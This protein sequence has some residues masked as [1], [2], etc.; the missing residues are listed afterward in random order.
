[1]DLI[2]DIKI[3]EVS[4]DDEGEY[5]DSVFEDSSFMTEAQRRMIFTQIYIPKDGGM[6]SILASSGEVNHKNRPGRKQKLE[7]LTYEEKLM[8]K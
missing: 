3:E 7:H 5:S 4:V 2:D 8:R 1:M 6:H